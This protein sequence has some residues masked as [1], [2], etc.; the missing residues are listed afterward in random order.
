MKDER[1]KIWHHMLAIHAENVFS[2]GLISS[3][4]Q[5][6]VISDSLHN[7]PNKGIYNWDPGAHFGI[8]RPDTFW[9]GDSNKKMQK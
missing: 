9:F 2:I 8:H 6:V 5:P 7:V 1:T 4:P 3:V